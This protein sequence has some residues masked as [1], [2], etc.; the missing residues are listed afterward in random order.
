M[1]SPQTPEET[2]GPPGAVGQ[3]CAEDIPQSW[4]QSPYL[5]GGGR[6]AWAGGPTP[7]GPGGDCLVET[8]MDGD[9]SARGATAEQG[10]QPRGDSGPVPLPLCAQVPPVG[11]A[12]APTSLGS[13]DLNDK[14]NPTQ[15][16]TEAPWLPAQRPHPTRHLAASAEVAVG[17]SGGH[18]GT[19]TLSAFVWPVSG[20]CG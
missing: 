19:P 8:L 10:A 5:L 13:C 2:L 11:E 9:H 6:G 14:T 7:P 18:V 16:H 15:A 1:A 3:R 17:L 12:A 20:V 4:P